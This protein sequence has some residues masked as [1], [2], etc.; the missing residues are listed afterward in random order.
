[1]RKNYNIAVNGLGAWMALAACTIQPT[2][3]QST[4]PVVLDTGELDES[5]AADAAGDT[6]GT[7]AGDSGDDTTTAGLDGSSSGG[8]A[9]STDAAG[10]SGGDTGGHCGDGIRDVGEECDGPVDAT[11]ASIGPQ[12]SDGVLACGPDCKLD[13]S[14]CQTCQAPALEPCDELS[15]DPL[16]ALEL[17]CDTLGDSWDLGNAVRLTSDKLISP[18]TNAFRT[19]RRF[20]THPSAWSPRAGNK[21]LLIGTGGFAP[22]G[23]DGV[24]KM[25][26]G[27]AQDGPLNNDMNP[28]SKGTLP[29][30]MRIKP[31]NGNPKGAEPFAECDNVNDCSNTLA[32]QWAVNGGDALD[33]F[34]LEFQTVVPV[35]T[36]GFALDLAFF[37]SHYPE[38]NSSD[39]NDMAVVW[40]ESEAY[41]GNVAYLHNGTKFRPLTLP[42]IVTAGWLAFDGNGA[43]ELEG[44]GYDG[45]DKMQGG[46][47]PWLTLEGPATPGETLTVAIAIFDLDDAHRDSALLLDHWRWSCAG[48]D[49]ATTCGL[50]LA[51]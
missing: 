47:T 33:I 19:P 16:H 21:A 9:D 14:D 50:R 24:L 37:T 6:S 31:F 4:D 34:Y 11:C 15:V 45:D 30:S 2:S 38:Y 28:D 20:G 35:G 39:Y 22:T 23:L 10:S 26:P 1:M 17:G 7:G 32:A 36:H 41:V 49:P 43:P 3:S 40:A 8:E 46:A 51:D 29:P 13:E 25:E 12:Y 27:S 18:D 5:S 44:T 42:D 48:C